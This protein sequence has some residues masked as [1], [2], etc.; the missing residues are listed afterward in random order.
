MTTTKIDARRRGLSIRLL[1]GTIETDRVLLEKEPPP[2]S[3]KASL[4]SSF[5]LVAILLIIGL[6]W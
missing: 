2:C 4:M 3:M 1:D 6:V 5:W